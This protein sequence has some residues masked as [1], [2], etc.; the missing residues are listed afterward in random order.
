MRL[1]RAIAAALLL[2]AALFV[3][4][5]GRPVIVDERDLFG[6]AC[7]SSC[8]QA[9]TNNNFKVGSSTCR[10][11]SQCRFNTR[12][13]FVVGKGRCDK[14]RCECEGAEDEV[15]VVKREN[16]QVGEKDLLGTCRNR[17]NS[18]SGIVRSNFQGFA[19]RPDLEL[20]VIAAPCLTPCSC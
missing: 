15:V 2:L 19:V 11:L 8:E 14:C 1:T 7:R 3:T 10:T 6:G 20:F 5:H 4:A 18:R 16:F 13:P 9:G 12:G 17:C